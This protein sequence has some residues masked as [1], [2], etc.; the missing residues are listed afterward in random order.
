MIKQKSF[1]SIE[2]NGRTYQ[3]VCENDSPLGE[4]HDVLMEIK[5]WAVERMVANQQEEQK[6]AEKQMELEK[7]KDEKAD[8]SL[9]N[10]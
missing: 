3:L 2:K 1:I 7:E 4:L 9:P 6:A 5:A 10:G 8:E